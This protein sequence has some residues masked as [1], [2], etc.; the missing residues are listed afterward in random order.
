MKGSRW[1]GLVGL[2]LLAAACASDA[3]DKGGVDQVDGVIKGSVTYAGT[4]AVTRLAAAVFDDSRYPPATM[5]VAMAYSPADPVAAGIGFPA[6]FEVTELP[7]GDLYLMVYGDVDP[8]DGPL[9]KAIDPASEWIGPI[10]ISADARVH[11]HDTTLVDG[12][13]H[14]LDTDVVGYFEGDEPEVVE[15]VATADAGDL[16]PATGKAT[17]H[18][19]VTYA[20]DLVGKLVVIGFP[21]DPAEG[22]GMP[23]ILPPYTAEGATFPHDYALTSVAPG[24]HWV[25]AYLDVDDSDGMANTDKDPVS[26]VT[27]MDLAAGD[28]RQLDLTLNLP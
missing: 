27:R 21:K 4:E 1:T 19:T 25:Y 28:V 5:P 16:T 17:L 8:D 2:V 24:A 23:S 3:I 20:G 12:Q 9:P 26:E 22:I 10:T 15:E 11:T 18:G 6:S 13:W 7:A 14:G